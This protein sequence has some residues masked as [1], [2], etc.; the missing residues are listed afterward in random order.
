MG[1][2]TRLLVIGPSALR[3]AVARA[4][5]NCDVA[6]A[7]HA[8]AGVWRTGQETF[9]GVC[10]SLSHG[11]KTFRAIRSLREIRPNA[12]IVVACGAADEP[13][14]RHALSHGAD[15][16]VLEPV[17]REDL[18]RAFHLPALHR[19]AMPPDTSRPTLREVVQ[20]SGVLKQLGDGPAATLERLAELIRQ[21]FGAAGVA[22]QL[23]GLT[24]SAGDATTPVLE[25][26]ILRQDKPVGRVALARKEEGSYAASVGTRLA[27]YAR[28]IDVTVAQAHEQER[29]R[30]LAWTDDLSG[31]R[32]RRYFEKA[33]AELLTRATRQRLHLTILLFDIDDFKTYNDRC[34]HET[35]D[36]L[37]REVA[38][39]LTLCSRESDVVA[40]YGGDE[41]GV[42]LWDADKPRVPGSQHPKEPIA[43][44]ERFRRAI[45][46][47][48]F[49]CLGADSPGPVTISGGLAAFPWN[50][51]TLQ[52]LLAAADEALLAAKRCG[53]NRIQLANDTEAQQQPSG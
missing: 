11:Q 41:F 27:E 10:L 53:K 3:E 22:V 39:L 35:G 13:A 50:G 45:G 18:E 38:R 20:L 1:G 23:D 14:A 4:L 19:L 6:L 16:Y 25:E 8:L 24:A 49:K 32:N 52:E 37:I 26:I 43:L 15:E 5:P 17:Q 12:H 28:L 9:D 51:K 21:A 40:R 44:A 34:G 33:L 36:E 48:D 30:D 7:E 29:W 42:I 31:L 2:Q 46:E 47:H